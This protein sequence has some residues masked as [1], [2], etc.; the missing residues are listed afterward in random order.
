[1]NPVK[2]TRIATNGRP[3]KGDLGEAFTNST[4]DTKS[5]FD[6]FKDIVE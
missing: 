3:K 2:S 1:M 4:T 5:V 6:A